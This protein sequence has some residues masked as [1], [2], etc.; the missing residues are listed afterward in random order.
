MSR[1]RR[2]GRSVSSAR[3][4][5]SAFGSTCRPFGVR[6]G[7]RRRG[8]WGA[9]VRA[10]WTVTLIFSPSHPK[11]AS[12]SRYASP[13]L[14]SAD[15]KILSRRRFCLYFSIIPPY[16]VVQGHILHWGLSEEP[17]IRTQY[18]LRSL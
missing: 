10:P 14:Q 6:G 4:S 13:P 18:C 7:R 17:Q 8:C 5:S 16:L 12:E 9:S 15:R 11:N 1:S 2:R 3:T